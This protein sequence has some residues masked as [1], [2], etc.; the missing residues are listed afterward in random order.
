MAAASIE[1]K[2]AATEQTI[3]RD[4]LWPLRAV[5][6]G[7]VEPGTVVSTDE[8]YSYSLLTCDGFEHNSVKRGGDEYSRNDYVS[9]GL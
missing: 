8:F 9:F 6:V 4:N 7:N 3:P 1:G 2:K 5:V